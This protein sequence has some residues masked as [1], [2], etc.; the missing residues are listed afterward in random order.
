MT[1]LE[2]AIFL[3]GTDL[4]HGTPSDTLTAIGAIS[5][6]TDCA[7]GRTLFSEA[8]PADAFYV[9]VSGKMRYQRDGNDMRIREPGEILG[10]WSLFDGDLRM[11]TA[12]ALE[13]ARLLRIA[14][15]DFRDLVLDSMDLG[16]DI[17]RVLAGEIG[18]VIAR[19]E[20]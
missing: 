19:M 17:H 8:D 12:T 5:R 18:G 4:F 13:D 15:D 2:K 9:L 1:L 11:F 10:I 16:R 14:Y 6:E 20:R 7:A 3:Q